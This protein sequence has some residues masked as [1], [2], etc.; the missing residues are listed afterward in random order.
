MNHGPL[1][2]RFGIINIALLL[3]IQV[4]P[5]EIRQPAQIRGNRPRQPIVRKRQMREIGK[6]PQ[7]RRN[8]PGQAAVCNVQP[9]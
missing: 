1:L 5:R 3:P 7:L 6:L 4:K 2:P 8:L 9:P